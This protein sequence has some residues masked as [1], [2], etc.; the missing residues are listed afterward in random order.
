MPCA[1]LVVD[2]ERLLGLGEHGVREV[3]DRDPNVRVVEVD[4]DRHTRRPV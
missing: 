2:V 3:R 4:A 1:R